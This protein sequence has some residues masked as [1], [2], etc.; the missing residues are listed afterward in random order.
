MG[1]LILD[2]RSRVLLTLRNLPPEA[3]A[4]SIVGGKL[5]YLETLAECALREAR[6]EVGVIVSLQGLLCVTD[7]LLPQ[8]NQH[9]VSPAYWGRVL[10]GRA[11]NCEPQK[12]GEV[13]WFPLNQLP[14]NLT[15]TARN[16]IAAYT[17]QFSQSLS[18]HAR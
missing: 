8:E 4:W 15:M 17:R 14:S 2:R 12:T 7:H 5:E 3:G 16:A 6:E 11:K 18:H 13:R 9:W 10:K 1:V